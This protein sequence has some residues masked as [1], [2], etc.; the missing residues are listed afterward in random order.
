MKKAAG[1]LLFPL[2]RE[3]DLNLSYPYLV[4][5]FLNTY[6][7]NNPHMVIW[8]VWANTFDFPVVFKRKWNVILV[9]TH[10]LSAIFSRYLLLHYLCVCCIV[11]EKWMFNIL[12]KS[13]KFSCNWV[14]KGLRE[15]ISKQSLYLHKQFCQFPRQKIYVSSPIYLINFCINLFWDFSRIIILQNNYVSVSSMR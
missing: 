4:L 14:R 7:L 5:S 3:P 2:R 6:S 13:K 15:Y 10:F 1:S 11:K 9:K 12:L 8:W